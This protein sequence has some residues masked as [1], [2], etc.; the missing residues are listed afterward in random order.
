MRRLLLVLCLVLA[1]A[2]SAYLAWQWRDMPQTGIFLDDSIYLAS[3]RALANGNGYRIDSIPGVPWQTKYPILLPLYLSLSWLVEPGFPQVLPWIMLLCWLALP[4]CILAALALY[5]NAGFGNAEKTLLCC[6]LAVN[7]VLVF[8][9]LLAM[10]E[11]TACALLLVCMVYLERSSKQHGEDRP[12]ALAGLFA[13]FAFLARTALFP[14]LISAPVFFLV[15]RRRR[16]AL[17]FLG[18]ALP[19][20]AGWQLWAATHKPVASDLETIF[21]TDY[22]RFYLLNLKETNI[23]RLLYDNFGALLK[24]AGELLVFQEAK[25]F[26]GVVPALI[27]AV[28]GVAGWVRLF[29]QGRLRHYAVFAALFLTQHLVYN[30][31]PTARFL[32]PILPGLLAAFSTEFRHILGLVGQHRR[33]QAGAERVAGYALACALGL[34]GAFAVWRAAQGVFRWIPEHL[35]AHRRLHEGRLPALHWISEN[36]R[37]DDILLSTFEPVAYLYTGRRGL[38][39]CLLTSLFYPP[40]KELIEDYFRRVSR[41]VHERNIAYVIL[42][43]NDYTMEEPQL[44]FPA[45]RRVLSDQTVFQKVFGNHTAEVYRVLP[46]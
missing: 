15:Q 9:S 13:G 31:P 33:R 46:R 4:A 8:F 20:V 1:L 32:L 6:L 26:S 45:W 19:F 39:F 22:F 24:S 28:L 5:R 42:T 12:A 44:T 17:L 18:A 11:V 37:P 14:V 36:S 38:R 29:R 7:P 30:F 40:R 27:A 21:Y 10:S 43:A 25:G 34:F 16:Q 3:A 41:F 35:A 2:P 23:G